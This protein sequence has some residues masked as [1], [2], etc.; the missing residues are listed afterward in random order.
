M[1]F[2]AVGLVSCSGGKLVQ[3]ACIPSEAHRIAWGFRVGKEDGFGDQDQNLLVARR[4]CCQ[5]HM[6]ALILDR[7]HHGLGPLGRQ[8]HMCKPLACKPCW[9]WGAVAKLW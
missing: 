8:T 3:S 6:R 1:G 4:P 7:S 2:L 5:R 9:L